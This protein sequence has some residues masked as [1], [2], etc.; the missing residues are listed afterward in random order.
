MGHL[1]GQLFAL[2]RSFPQ[3]RKTNLTLRPR[4]P[5]SLGRDTIPRSARCLMTVYIPASQ[6]AGVWPF[7]TISTPENHL[8]R[9]VLSSAPLK[10][11]AATVRRRFQ[12][13]ASPS[14]HYAPALPTNSASGPPSACSSSV[15]FPDLEPLP[16]LE[17]GCGAGRATLGLWSLGYRHLTAF[18]FADK[19]SASTKPRSLSPPSA[20]RGSD[21]NFLH[22]DATDL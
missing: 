20:R 15:S 6:S 17:A 18:D 11:P 1:N 10:S 22:A 7:M 21:I 12:R 4:G 5:I 9:A 3:L 8:L 16:L 14:S 19:N 2:E 13:S